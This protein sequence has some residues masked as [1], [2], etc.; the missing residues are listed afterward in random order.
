MNAEEG[1]EESTGDPRAASDNEPMDEDEILGPEVSNGGE[2]GVAS[3]TV[4]HS[5]DRQA[6]QELA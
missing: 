5:V 2:L 1:A 6:W 4:Y 3:K